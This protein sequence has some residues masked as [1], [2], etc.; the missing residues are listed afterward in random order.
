MPLE[1]LST[2]ERFLVIQG[3]KGSIAG[4]MAMTE[5]TV[6]NTRATNEL[7]ISM[8]NADKSNKSLTIWL[9]RFTL[10]LV[11]LTTLLV[12]LTL[13]LLFKK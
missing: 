6:R 12:T 5:A 11:V 8:E 2:E 7:K 1:D 10:A 3:G 9:I 4:G 13:A